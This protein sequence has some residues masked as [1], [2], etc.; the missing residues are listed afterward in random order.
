MS[1]RKAEGKEHAVTQH[2]SDQCSDQEY[3]MQL[4]LKDLFSLEVL[5]WPVFRLCIRSALCPAPGDVGD[6]I[7]PERL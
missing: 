7:T 1:C 5:N 3:L 4:A 6:A 2:I